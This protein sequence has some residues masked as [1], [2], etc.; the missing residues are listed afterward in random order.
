MIE[1][2]INGL[3]VDERFREYEAMGWGAI[4]AGRRYDF[5]NVV[6]RLSFIVVIMWLGVQGF[7]EYLAV[8]LF[9]F[10]G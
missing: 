7:V 8:L 1:N 4:L 10:V 6:W 2:A 5:V 9:G 3:I